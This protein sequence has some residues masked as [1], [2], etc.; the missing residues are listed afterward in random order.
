MHGYKILHG[1]DLNEF[2]NFKGGKLVLHGYN[3]FAWR[4]DL[5]QISMFNDGKL[6]MHGYNSLLG[7][8]LNEWHF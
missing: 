1:W 3:N 2:G 6:V 7:G 5:S 8:D 4:G